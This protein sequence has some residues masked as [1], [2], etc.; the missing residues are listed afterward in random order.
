MLH[1]QVLL[2][3]SIP[4][5]VLLLLLVGVTSIANA[6]YEITA[7]K[8]SGYFRGIETT[9]S[10]SVVKI[11]NDQNSTDILSASICSGGSINIGRQ[12]ADFAT[13]IERL[14]I[15]SGELYL[16]YYFDEAKGCIENLYV[17]RP[18]SNNIGKLNVSIKNK[19]L[20]SKNETVQVYVSNKGVP[21]DGAIVSLT[22]SAAPSCTTLCIEN[23]DGKGLYYSESTTNSDGYAYFPVDATI[24]SIN[25]LNASADLYND[26]GDKKSSPSGVSRKFVSIGGAYADKGVVTAVFLIILPIISI[27]GYVIYRKKHQKV[28]KKKSGKKRK[29]VTR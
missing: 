17:S 8:N 18:A 15:L 7:G 5:M 6:S 24:H 20:S 9:S 25:R 12:K 2:I 11:S 29:Y 27:F 14:K 28:N 22:I 1:K 19:L 13:N 23:V 4:L 3:S 16:D 10:G 26:L 21:I